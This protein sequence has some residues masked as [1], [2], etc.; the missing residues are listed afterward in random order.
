MYIFDFN[1]YR[2]LSMRGYSTYTYVFGRFEKRFTG[3]KLWR[4]SSF[5]F[6]LK[7]CDLLWY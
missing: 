2:G 6:G 3:V 4:F 1:V 5:I 7:T